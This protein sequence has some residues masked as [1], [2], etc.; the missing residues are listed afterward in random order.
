MY[1][2]PFKELKCNPYEDDLC[3]TDPS[4]E[5]LD[6]PDA[7]CAF[8]HDDSHGEENLAKYH[9]TKSYSSRELAEEAGGIVT[10]V[11]SCG[12]CSNA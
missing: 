1:L 12:L 5:Y 3:E 4:Q 6:S 9:W 11:G 8:H 7:V 10:H 2:N